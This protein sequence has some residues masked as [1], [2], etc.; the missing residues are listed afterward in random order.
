MKLTTLALA[1]ASLAFMATANAATL[2]VGNSNF[3]FDGND[4]LFLDNAGNPLTSGFVALSTTPDPSGIVT[5]SLVT[6]NPGN[7]PGGIGI[8]NS[9][10]NAVNNGA[11]TGVNLF[12]LVGDGLDVASSSQFGAL[13]TGVAFVKADTPPP[14]DSQFYTALSGHVVLGTVGSV[15]VDGSAL[16]G[17]A[18]YNTTGLRLVPEPS[19]TLLFGLAGLA[20]LIRRRR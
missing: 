20:L 14:P 6:I 3:A 1:V 15:T 19:S 9:P 2:N 18:T 13:N 11:L 16:G 4:L 17:P 5:G 10:L 7:S 12:I 8:F